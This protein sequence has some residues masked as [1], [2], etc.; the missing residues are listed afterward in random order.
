M[1]DIF[2]KLKNIK[3]NYSSPEIEKEAQNVFYILTFLNYLQIRWQVNLNNKIDSFIE[4]FDLVD[5]NKRDKLNYF[6]A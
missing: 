2:E 6:Y 1:E 4:F 5:W 3:S